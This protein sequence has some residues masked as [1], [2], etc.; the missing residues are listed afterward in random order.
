MI[1]RI[2]KIARRT[3]VLIGAAALS[4]AATM[5]WNTAIAETPAGGHRLGNPAAKVRLTE[6]VSYSCPHCGAYARESE[7]GLR[8][9]YVT[10]G[11]LSV[12]VRPVIRNPV[13]LVA[14]ILVQCG[15]KEKFFLNH[16]AFLHSQD[17]WMDKWARMGPATKQRW[18]SGAF[19]SRMRAI[20]EDLDFFTIMSRRGYTRTQTEQC[21]SNEAAARDLAQKSADGARDAGVTATPSF[22]LNGKLL[23]DVHTWAALQT[24][25]AKALTTNS[26]E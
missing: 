20:A 23:E 12:E 15:S 24:T 10:P 9:V 16:A 3:A 25:I 18:T 1:S 19:P 26:V 22:V 7:A 11:N 17:S 21:L 4:L 2:P 8:I 14:T 6:F 5:N 13:D